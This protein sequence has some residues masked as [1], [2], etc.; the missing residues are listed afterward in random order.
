MGYTSIQ[1]SHGSHLEYLGHG[2]Y[3]FLAELYQHVTYI[4]GCDEC[5]ELVHFARDCCRGRPFSQKGHR[6]RS[7]AL[8]QSTKCGAKSSDGGHQGGLGCPLSGRQSGQGGHG[9]M[10][11][12]PR[13]PE[14]ESLDVII[15]GTISIYIC[16]CA[17]VRTYYVM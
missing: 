9:H 3:T 13:R 10:H 16:V 5:G 8:I 1:T 7:K 4:H 12:F 2:G 15:T 6:S 11:A 17:C 14:E